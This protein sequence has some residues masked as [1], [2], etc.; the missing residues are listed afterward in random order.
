MT[1]QASEPD[2]P[3]GQA[4]E[5]WTRHAL[6]QIA[7]IALLAALVALGYFGND[8]LKLLGLPQRCWEYKEIDGRLYKVNP[9]TGQF[10]L[11]GD[12]VPPAPA[13]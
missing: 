7:V 3:A 4:P 2:A 9:C 5:H 13:Q 8:A 11:V 6:R 10:L 12:V 1:D